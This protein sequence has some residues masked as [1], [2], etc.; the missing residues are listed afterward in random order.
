MWTR[1]HSGDGLGLP[2]VIREDFSYLDDS[3]SVQKHKPKGGFFQSPE[4]KFCASLQKPTVLWKPQ[5]C[6]DV[7]RA[8]SDVW[9]EAA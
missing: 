2:V 4:A 6:A 8:H 7:R 9:K 5:T 1:G 3:L